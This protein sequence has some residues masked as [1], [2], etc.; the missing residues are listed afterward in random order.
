MACAM[1][2]H[3]SNRSINH[4]QYVQALL[5]KRKQHSIHRFCE[6]SHAYCRIKR[7]LP[8]WMRFSIEN[9]LALCDKFA[10]S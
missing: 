9:A 4:L 5:K 8:L 3:A 2:E 1:M 7:Y 6:K 10:F